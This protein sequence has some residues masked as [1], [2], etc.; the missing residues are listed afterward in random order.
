MISISLCMIVKNEEDVI[1]R[2]L[3]SVKNVADEIIIVDTGSQD[4]TEEIARKYTKNIYH[5][6]W[7]D[8]FSAA[9]NFS[10]SKATKDYILWLDADDVIEEKYQKMF[11]ELKQS[12]SPEVDIV[13]LPYHIAFDE[14]NNPT[15][16]YYRE[17]LIRRQAHF[18]WAGAIH[19]AIVPIGNIV[20]EKPAISHKKLHPSDPDRNIRIFEKLLSQG[21][22]LEPREQFYYARELYYHKQYQKA[23][24]VFEK[25]LKEGKG[26]QENNISACIDL[27][28]CYK[29]LQQ[30]KK[31]L[32]ALFHSFLYDI[33]RGEACCEIGNIFLE[34]K[35]Y[36]K[37]IYWFETAVHQK[38]DMTSC[39]FFVLDHYDFIPYL[40]LCVC[41]SRM[42]D[43][44]TAVKYHNLAKKCRPKNEIVLQNEQYFK[45][46]H[47]IESQY[48]SEE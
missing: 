14:E 31:A 7:I 15:Y 34:Q 28:Q 16:S 3:E 32:D 21:K 27:C 13:M 41:Y 5:F 18:H 20:F 39:G 42:G 48:D 9:R 23:I 24:A 1:G 8:D 11:L 35:Q 45:S 2:C 33:P 12:L 19:E 29:G 30:P 36:Q 17:R 38:P 22:Q 40:Q 47:L 43:D 4:K 26:W 10:F 46:K 6:A 37:A 25:F 44:K